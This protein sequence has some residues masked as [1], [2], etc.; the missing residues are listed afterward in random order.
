VTFGVI[1]L[2]ALRLVYLIFLRLVCWM[3]LLA[4][5][6]NTNHWWDSHHDDR[7][8]DV[9]AI[10]APRTQTGHVAPG[11]V[12]LAAGCIRLGRR[13]AEGTGPGARALAIPDAED[14]DA[15]RKVGDAIAA[16]ISTKQTIPEVETSGGWCAPGLKSWKIHSCATACPNGW[17]PARSCPARLAA[18][19][20][21]RPPVPGPLSRHDPTGFVFAKSRGDPFSPGYLTHT[22]RRLAAKAGVPPI[23]LHDLRH[24]AASLAG[25]PVVS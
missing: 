13:R 8:G 24:G 5:A 1:H 23:R 14:T 25:P 16:A 21:P 9:W 12:E 17:A 4:F 10:P 2:V 22:F 15:L 20:S 18:P 3:A 6:R 19:T 11:P 7:V